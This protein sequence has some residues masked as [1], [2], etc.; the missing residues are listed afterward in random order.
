[1]DSIEHTKQIF[2]GNYQMHDKLYYSSNEDLYQLLDHVDITNKKVL[3]VLASGDQYFHLSERDPR[4]IDTFDI[5]HLTKYYFYLRKWGIIYHDLYYPNVFSNE[6][7]YSIIK[8]V[9]PK[10]KNEEEAL[11]YW[12]RY[13][14][15]FYSYLTNE[16]IYLGQDPKKNEIKNLRRL[17]EYL[18]NQ[19]FRFYHMDISKDVIDD[20][21]DFIFISNI[22]EYYVLNEKAM[23]GLSHNLYQMLEEDGEVLLSYVVEPRSSS[24]EVKCFDN[25][26]V[27]SSILDNDG[28]RIG[29]IYKKRNV[30]KK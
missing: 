16:L 6:T 8:E 25:F 18:L 23:N 7:I 22:A 28:D 24:M 21:Y 17:K 13:I 10:D 12:E 5:N 9:K 3:S 27:S 29:K 14:Q 4:I 19:E 20:K 15:T 30:N 26:L 11:N 2:L 1:M